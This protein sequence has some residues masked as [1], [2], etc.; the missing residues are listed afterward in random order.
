MKKRTQYLTLVGT[1]VGIVSGLVAIYQFATHS[2]SPGPSYPT[3]DTL[4]QPHRVEPTPPPFP[5]DII[6]KIEPG[7]S[8]RYVESLLGV[9]VSEHTNYRYYEAG[10][11]DFSVT[12][13]GQ[14]V[15]TLSVGPSYG[16]S[17]TD[18]APLELAGS[19]GSVDSRFGEATFGDFIDEFA[20]SLAGWNWGGNAPCHQQ[21]NLRCGGSRAQEFFIVSPGIAAP[22]C[23]SEE[24]TEM[25]WPGD[26]GLSPDL[27]VDR[28][29][30]RIDLG[31]LR[32][33]KI[34]KIAVWSSWD[35][36]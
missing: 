4:P 9:P 29:G 19:W 1:L 31:L 32:Q 28:D 7:A 5:S 18:L 23:Y 25:P 13:N 6:K 3:A 27:D 8:I 2:A 30:H 21:I 24:F 12:V 26:L 33:W 16:S 20:C 35:E 14:S 36:E 17:V 11:F 10:G 22:G 34:N 15:T